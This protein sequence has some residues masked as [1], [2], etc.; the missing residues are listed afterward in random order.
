MNNRVITVILIVALVFCILITL[1]KLF[2][3]HLMGNHEDFEPVQPIAFSHRLHAGELEISCLYC[4]SGAEKSRHAGVPATNI[5]MNCHQFVQALFGAIRAEDELAQEEERDPKKIVS[6]E[7]QK[8]YDSLGL[9]E[10]LQ[11]DPD[12]SKTPIE[13]VK[14]Y[15]VPDFVYFDHRRHVNAGVDCQTCHGQVQTMERIKQVGNLSMGWCVNCHRDVTQN[16]FKGKMMNASTD[17]SG[18][19]Y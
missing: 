3:F 14:V 1:P 5:C 11:E 19:H 6:P 18:C 2:G 8:I 7:I 10:N 4:H 16:G 13:W 17:C 9:D 12:K 15:H